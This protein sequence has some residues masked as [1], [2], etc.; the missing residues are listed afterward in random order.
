MRILK[1]TA[2]NFKKLSVV[3][4]TPD[5]N[6]VLI[7]GKNG[8]GKSSIMD[9][10]EAALCGGRNLPKQ[11]I[12]TGE[13]SAVI[14]TELGDGVPKYKVTRKFLGA[15]SRLTVESIGENTVAE[16][17]SPQTFLDS[18]VGNISFDPLAFMKLS[19]AEQRT[20]IV[21]FLGLQLD[22]FD[23]K[24]LSLKNERSGVRKEKEKRQY[25]ADSIVFTPNLPE[26]EQGCDALLAELQGIRE[27]NEK[28][29][30]IAVANASHRSQLT[31]YNEDIK[32][33]QKALL[34]WQKRLDALADQRNDLVALLQNQ[35]EVPTKDPA[36]VEQKIATLNE[37]NEAIRR[38]TQ[39]RQALADVGIHTA[40]YSQLGT[41]I[42]A[43]E[44]QKAKKM[45][46]AVMPIEGLSI[47]PEGLGYNG[48][49][50]E[51][52]CD[53]KK[54]KI[55]VAIAMALNPK[56]KVLRI[57]GNELDSE[58]LAAIGELVAGK[59][60]QVWIEKVADDNKIG[61]F[62]EDGHLVGKVD[63]ENPQ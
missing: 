52:E 35:P 22:D 4:I 31:R 41:D 23:Q 54:L 43:V 3:E 47:R 12:K 38:N 19:P 45:A 20:T 28:S 48:L 39:R 58:S 40:A 26:E 30:K 27:H 37:T 62:V 13:E 21:D 53:S 60:Y 9:A 51:Q 44:N 5:G 42:K 61:F 34:D 7:T 11:P 56:L 46:E 57:N 2:E 6:V 32:A 8:Q 1:L 24:I 33:A 50:L 59:D 49:P 14:V 25:D 36:N 10:M 29:Q 18:I 63:D 17:R 16:V 15:S 55:C